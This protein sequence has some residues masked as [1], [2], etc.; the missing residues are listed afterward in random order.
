M[1]DSRPNI[2]FILTD[3]LGAWALNYTGNSEI[4]MPN[5]DK[6]AARGARFDSFC[7]TSSVCSPCVA[8]KVGVEPTGG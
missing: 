5:I 4:K 3:D 1:S 2:I 6:L 7:C 8:E